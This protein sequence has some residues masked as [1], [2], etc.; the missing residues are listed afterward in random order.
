MQ[1]IVAP[2]SGRWGRGGRALYTRGRYENGLEA[3]R[4]LGRAPVHVACFGVPSRV[5]ALSPDP[6]V[7][8][9]RPDPSAATPFVAPS[10][11]GALNNPDPSATMTCAELR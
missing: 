3:R 2:G 5:G 11:A 4:K 10:R 8:T 9:Q 6:S 1:V 7:P